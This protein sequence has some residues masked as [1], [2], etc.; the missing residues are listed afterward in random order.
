MSAWLTTRNS[1]LSTFNA[2]NI[3]YSTLSGS[4]LNSSTINASTI[5]DNTI[6]TSQV[7]YS[8]LVGSSIVSNVVTGSVIG[9]NAMTMSTI[10][11]ATLSV[12]SSTSTYTAGTL[13]VV[14][15]NAIPA[16]SAAIIAPNMSLTGASGN[17]FVLGQ[18]TTLYNSMVLGWFSVGAGSTSNYLNINGYSNVTAGTGLNI[19]AGGSVGIG[20]TNPGYNLQVQG[21]IQAK[22]LT[23]FNWNSHA[24][25]TANYVPTV[26]YWKIASINQPAN[27]GHGQLSI[28]G[29]LGGWIVN[30]SDQ[31]SVDI[32]FMS[33]G[34]LNIEGIV[35]SASYS[36]AVANMDIGYYVNGTSTYDI[37]L[38]TKLQ[39]VSFDLDIGSS[40][41]QNITNIILY[42]PSV[43]VGTTTSPGALIS[44][45]A[46]CQMYING[47]N[48]GISISNPS[49]SL[50]VNTN[51]ILVTSGGNS[52]G[53]GGAI[54]F[55]VAAYPNA[56]PMSW[57]QG[58]L[59][60]MYVGSVPN[61]AQGGIGFYV[62]PVN[63][64]ATTSSFKAMTIN[65][66]GTIGLGSGIVVGPTYATTMYS[67]DTMY[68]QFACIYGSTNCQTM[69]CYTID[70]LVGG[71]GWSSTYS[72]LYVTKSIS[73]NR[74][75]NA[76]G[77]INAS[78]ADYAEYMVK[79]GTFTINKGDIV[80]IDSNGLLTNQYDNSI[81]FMIKS[82]NPSYVGGDVWGTE[83]IVGKR[84][85]L[86]EHPTEA[87][88]SAYN[89]AFAA[90]KAAMEVERQKVDRIAYSGQVPVNVQG[91]NPGDYII[92]IR[93]SDGSIGGQAVS[94]ASITFQQY[95]S[96]VGKVL[97]IL[98]D[99]RPNVKVL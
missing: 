49:A 22:N 1:V 71:S 80:G 59:E 25:G 54:K 30:T 96:A 82:T 64:S 76:A 70:P 65:S 79:S 55:G 37:Y 50:H 43:V 35:K 32:V 77:T 11:T 27:G 23:H 31:M 52:G 67:V 7:N 95:Q 91:A 12:N 34:I 99:G 21:S 68:G 4:T 5:F 75:I 41:A 73:T 17:L 44:I 87:D 20:I 60:N 89:L 6:T 15:T 81:N 61:Q 69:A 9:G 13:T 29:S 47:S 92:P 46:A 28:K 8:T 48:V 56:T 53:S 88:K 51:D 14:N 57:I 38:Y 94:S 78:G 97:N 36:N 10:S 33:R 58:T 86:P 98:A 83:E 66:N 3:N 40:G 74:S 90:W 24:L 39:Y 16:V 84:P 93:N 42:D 18:A 63:V 2:V 85:E 62:T 72:I 26:T 45:T 19:T